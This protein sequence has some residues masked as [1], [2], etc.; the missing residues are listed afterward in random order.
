MHTATVMYLL[1]MYIECC[2]TRQTLS[3]LAHQLPC[4]SP[5]ALDRS[6]RVPKSREKIAEGYFVTTQSG[7]VLYFHLAYETASSHDFE[8]AY[9]SRGLRRALGLIGKQGIL[10]QSLGL[11]SWLMYI[12][13]LAITFK[14]ANFYLSW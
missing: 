7:L 4:V 13:G 3:D 14:P 1:S 12:T 11:L 8:Q 2:V 10:V 9:R 6:K 5:I